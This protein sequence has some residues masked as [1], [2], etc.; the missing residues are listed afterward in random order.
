MS[1]SIFEH[2]PQPDELLNWASQHTIQTPILSNLH[3][4]T[5]YSF[6]AFADIHEAVNLAREQGIR[7]LGISDF[8]TTTGYDEFTQECGKG[9]IFP[10]Y[11]RQG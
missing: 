6:S 9:G 1:S 11:F 8:N 10:V 3:I 7:V 2:F 4:H 5:P